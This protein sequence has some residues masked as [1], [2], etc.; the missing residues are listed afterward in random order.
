M[1]GLGANE[2]H[3]PAHLECHQRWGGQSTANNLLDNAV[4]RSLLVFAGLGRTGWVDGES[5]LEPL[6]GADPP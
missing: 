3:R 1:Q 4:D 5:V 6:H 2:V